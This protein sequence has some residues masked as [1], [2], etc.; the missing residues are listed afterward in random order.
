MKLPMPT[1]QEITNIANACETPLSNTNSTSCRRAI[2]ENAIRLALSLVID[3][4][5]I[6][7]PQPIGLDLSKP[8]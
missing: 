8:Q 2:V 1:P 3:R 7:I 4:M 6:Q 5:D